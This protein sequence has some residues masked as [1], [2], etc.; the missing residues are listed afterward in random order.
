MLGGGY[1]KTG[2]TRTAL[3]GYVVPFLTISRWRLAPVALLPRV[4][5]S[6]QL[7]ID[8]DNRLMTDAGKTPADEVL[9]DA[10]TWPG[11]LRDADGRGVPLLIWQPSVRAIQ[12]HGSE[13]V[14]LE[15][16]DLLQRGLHLVTGR[17]SP[18]AFRLAVGWRAIVEHDRVEI[19]DAVGKLGI[20]MDSSGRSD[21]EWRHWRRLALDR[22]EVWVATG[23]EIA[24]PLTGMPDMLAA[25]DAGKLLVGAVPVVSP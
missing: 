13:T 20:S 14:D 10:T 3:P 22:R 2:W 16:R 23:P 19:R 6:A 18:E 11:E 17:L 5:G 24:D 15:V 25:R 21:D 8:G 1:D 9:D 4:R 12:L 7:V